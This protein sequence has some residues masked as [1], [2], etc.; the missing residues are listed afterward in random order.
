VDLRDGTVD[1]VLQHA[2]LVGKHDLVPPQIQQIRAACARFVLV[3]RLDEEIRRAAFE[4]VVTNLADR[5]RP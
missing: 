5:R 4:R 2:R 1:L 3:E